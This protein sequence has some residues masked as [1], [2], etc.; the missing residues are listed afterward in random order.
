MPQRPRRIWQILVLAICAL[1]GWYILSVLWSLLILLIVGFQEI[2]SAQPQGGFNEVV[3]WHYWGE[4]VNPF[5]MGTEEI[6]L[7]WLPTGIIVLTQ[8]AMLL[9]AVRPLRADGRPR[10]P[11]MAGLVG[12]ILALLVTGGCLLALADIPRIPVGLGFIGDSSLGKARSSANN[13]VEVLMTRWMPVLGLGIMLVSWVFWTIVLLVTLQ[14]APSGWLARTVR[15]LLV[16]SFV[17]LAIALPIYVIV[18]R[19]FDCWCSLPSFWAVV[20]SLAVVLA[21][22]G[23]GV[24]LLWRRRAD[25]PTDAWSDRCMVCGYRRAPDADARCPECGTRWGRTLRSST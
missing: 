1:L 20:S 18:R 5:A 3:D 17:E 24:V 16:G 6:T 14:K 8:F 21:L 23:P 13:Q 2:D 10:R 11:W 22:T 12:G 25:L 7:V 19:R 4:L 9:P 15:W